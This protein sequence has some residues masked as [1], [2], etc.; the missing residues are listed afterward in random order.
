MP[1]T[2]RFYHVCRCCRSRFEGHAAWDDHHL[3]RRAR[4]ALRCWLQA[5]CD[6]GLRVYARI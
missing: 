4:C 1:A 3:L 6:R 2:N 5:V